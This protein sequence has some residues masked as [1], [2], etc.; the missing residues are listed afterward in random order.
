M[1]VLAQPVPFERPPAR[2][3]DAPPTAKYVAYVNEVATRLAG[4]LSGRERRRLEGERALLA[5]ARFIELNGV[6]HHY[7]DVGPS[8]GQPLVLIHGWD[9]SSF[10]WHHV[11]DPLAQAGY[12]VISYDLKG[13]GFSDADP[14]QNYT[15]AGFSADLQ[16]LIRTLDL[17]AV[18]LAAF[19]LGAFV[20]LHVAAHHPDMV[21]SLIFFN[22]SLLPYNKL[23]SAFVPRLLDV[24]FN[25]VLRPI[26]RRNLWWLPFIYARLVMA[27]HTPSI[28]DIRLGT[29]GL[30]YCD[31]AAVRVSATEL[32]RPEIL[33]AVAEQAR[34]IRQ[35]LL[36]VAGANDP[37]MRPADSRKLIALTPNGS[38]LEVPKCGHLILFELPEQV[39]QIMRLFLKSVR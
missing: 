25:R 14:R 17:G 28:S 16:A 5:R 34:M 31:P 12:R 22:F 7:Q 15:V 36:L 30:R 6:V 37:I 27:Q 8:D 1:S 33:N 24:V 3:I 29:L 20:G 39:I 18:H 4:R 23:A 21:R 32:S 2:P 11:V 19:S 13:H 9:C 35:P 10:W 38:F 26:E